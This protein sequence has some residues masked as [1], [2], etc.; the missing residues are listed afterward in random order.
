MAGSMQRTPPMTAASRASRASRLCLAVSACVL[1]LVATAPPIAGQSGTPP[2]PARFTALYAF[3]DSLA[4]NGND[5]IATRA[6]GLNP[7]VPPSVSP[8]MAYYRGRFSN[9]PVA[10]EYLWQLISGRAPDTTG[11][12]RP[13]LESPLLRLTT[14]AINFSF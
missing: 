2:Q 14:R 13:F 1:T 8:H 5:L 4:D 12:L 3:G 7:A 11:S 9:G 10:F 6:I